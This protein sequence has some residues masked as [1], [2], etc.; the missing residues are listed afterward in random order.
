MPEAPGIK[1]RNIVNLSCR[2]D[3]P[4]RQVDDFR[5][6]VS[7]RSA[8]RRTGVDEQTIRVNVD[9]PFGELKALPDMIDKQ[10]DEHDYRRDSCVREVKN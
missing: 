10:S 1:P 5:F 9:A 4:V 7:I 8:Q 3:I 2:L 6:T